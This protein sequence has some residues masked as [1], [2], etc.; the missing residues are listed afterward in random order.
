MVQLF[1]LL[2]GPAL[3]IPDVLRRAGLTLD[4]MDVVELH[5]AFAGQLLA[6]L[7]LLQQ[8][9][10][11][12]ERLDRDQAVG[13]IDPD[14]L[15]AWGGSLS[16]GHPFGATGGRLVATCC[17][18]LEQEDGRYGLIAACASGGLGHAT[19]LERVGG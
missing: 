13:V 1:E 14:K 8:D 11:A 17:R 4:A 12:R 5:E 7:E 3:A 6:V 15:N 19:I 2:L 10:F 18:R 16:I 9:G